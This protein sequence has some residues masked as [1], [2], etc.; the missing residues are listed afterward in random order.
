MPRSLIAWGLFFLLLFSNHLLM[1]TTYYVPDDYA[2]IQE[3][4]SDSA[5]GDTIIVRPG[6]YYENVDFLG[7]ALLLKS[8]QGPSVTTI[9]GGGTGSVVT[10]ETYEDTSSI[11]DGFTITNGYAVDGGGI[12]CR[13][14]SPTIRNNT[15]TGNTAYPGNGGGIH[16][17]LFSYPVI[18][19]NNITGNTG[20]EYGGGVYCVSEA[21]ITGNM[22]VQNSADN[23]AGISC[24]SSAPTIIGNT[25]KDNSAAARGGGIY[26][27]LAS[28]PA[29]VNNMIAA[30]SAETGGGIS[31]NGSAAPY[32]S[33]NTIADNIATVEGGGLYGERLASPIVTNTILW[34][35]DS[36]Q[37]A[38]IGVGNSEIHSTL[39]ISFSD[40]EGGF[41]SVFVDSA[42]VLNWGIGNIDLDP[43]FSDNYYHLQMAS[44]CVDTGDSTVPDSCLPPGRGETW[45]DMGMYGGEYNCDFPDYLA[46][47]T[48]EPSG[49]VIVSRLGTLFFSTSIQS[50]IGRAVTGDYWLNVVLPDSSQI[51]IPDSFLNYANPYQADLQPYGSLTLSNE[52]FIPA[53]AY[54]GTYRLIGRIGVFP[55]LTVCEESFYF[56]VVP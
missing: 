47:L 7:K 40:V 36:P 16:G 48:M 34:G 55:N 20:G 10:F 24:Y 14:S 13:I 39:T 49:S 31:C 38:Q 26:C 43:F 3:A 27:Y 1:G 53:P 32:I 18:T 46:E 25:I 28:S 15:I 51:D 4:I 29:I 11:I 5:N 54:L 21:E 12:M 44:P 2:T 50:N 35:N 45:T 23:G 33:N 6:T 17:Y 9:D 30:N 52:L 56:E 41:D 8:E 42:C 37:A 19:D 22:I